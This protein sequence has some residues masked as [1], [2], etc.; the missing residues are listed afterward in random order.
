MGFFPTTNPAQHQRFTFTRSRAS[1]AVASPITITG[2]SANFF[3]GRPGIY[4]VDPQLHDVATQGDTHGRPFS[5]SVPTIQ[6][7]EGRPI[8]GRSVRSYVWQTVHADCARHVPKPAACRR[9]GSCTKTQTRRQSMIT[10]AVARFSYF[11]RPFRR[12]A[13]RHAP[14]IEELYVMRQSWRSRISGLYRRFVRT[15]QEITRR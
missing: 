1:N 7:G 15:I 3:S 8:S 6:A 12:G 13:Y 10:G 14:S 4:V 9:D 2:I 5:F 11:F